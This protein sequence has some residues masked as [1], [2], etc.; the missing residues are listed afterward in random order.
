MKNLILY[1]GGELCYRLAIYFAQRNIQVKLISSKR[2]LNEVAVNA[3]TT[4]NVQYN[5]CQSLT[6]VMAVISEVYNLSNYLHVSVGA[7]WIFDKNFLQYLNYD[8]Y[9]I[10]GTGLPKFRGAANISWQIMSGCPMSSCTLHQIDEGIDTGPIV[11][12]Q[13]FLY[14]NS[15]ILP[16]D[17]QNFYI[18]KN[19]EVFTALFSKVLQG[20]LKFKPIPQHRNGATYWPR[21]KAEV[22]GAIDWNLEATNLIRFIR[23]FDDPYAGAFTYVNNNRIVL[24]N[25]SI[26][27]SEGSFHPY[28]FGLVYNI[29]E[30]LIFIGIN[31]GT[32]ICSAS[33]FAKQGIKV[34]VGDRLHTPQELIERAKIRQTVQP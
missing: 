13:P 30:D 27:F 24:K 11:Y 6:E 4:N 7:P 34:K 17:Y 31:G 2:Y 14:P 5:C 3:L 28:Q 26:D 9:N 18:E 23:A 15:C 8:I 19:L 33:A 10:H 1:G 32:L 22:N 21:L 16:L 12:N 25:V 20:E 29:L